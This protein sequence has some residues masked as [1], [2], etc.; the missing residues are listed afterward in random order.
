M[1]VLACSH[2]AVCIGWLVAQMASVLESAMNMPT[3]FDTMVV[4]CLLLGFPIAMI[5]AWA[6]EMTP[7]GVK[8]TNS[9]PDGESV[10]S[11]SSAG[12]LKVWSLESGQ[13]A[14]DFEN[15]GSA[16]E[17]E[18]GFWEIKAKAQKSLQK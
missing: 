11:A 9:I 15:T 4:S 8:R 18:D 1:Q 2:L 5:L 10:V 12:D 16:V 7:E 6:F 14:S 17:Y 3:W 13:C